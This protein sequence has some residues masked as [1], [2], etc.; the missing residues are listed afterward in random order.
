MSQKNLNHCT[1]PN[2][3]CFKNAEVP[4]DE[5]T[6]LECGSETTINDDILNDLNNNENYDE[7]DDLDMFYEELIKEEIEKKT[8]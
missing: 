8:D 4:I 7:Y 1:N 3:D 6:C 2:C 5:V